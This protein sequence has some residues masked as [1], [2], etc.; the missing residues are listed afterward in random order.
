MRAGLLA[1]GLVALA[2]GCANVSPYS[3]D[4]NPVS[5]AGAGDGGLCQV[6]VD[7][8]PEV[9]IAGATATVIARSAIA[10]SVGLVSYRWTISH[11]GAPIEP[12]A[13]TDGRRDVEFP[14]PSPG[15]YSVWLEVGD[16]CQGFYGSLNVLPPGANTRAVRLRFVPPPSAQ[17]PPQEQIVTVTGGS[18]QTVNVI[19]LDAGQLFPVTVRAGDQP[20][21]AYL[22]FISRTTPDAAV[23]AFSDDSGAST[24]R[25]IAGQYDVLVV[26]TSAA[27]APRLITGFDPFTRA[28]TVDGGAAL[29]GVV[30][31]GAGVPVAGARVSVTSGATPS[32]V[33]TTAAD[34][35][36][37]LRWRDDP[38][39]TETLTIA[40]LAGGP[41]PRVDAALDLAGRSAVD[42]RFAPIATRDLAGLV[43]RA[44]GGPAVATEVVVHATVATAATLLDGAT[45]IGTAAGSYRRQVRTD[46]AGALPALQVARVPGA[47]VAA[48]AG[49]AAMRADLG[50]A[51]RFDLAT[52]TAT[53]RVLGRDGAPIGGGVTVRAVL[54]GE[55]AFA[56]A[57]VTTA[58]TTADGRFAI[59]IAAGVSY[60]LTVAAPT[61]GHAELA[62]AVTSAGSTAALG[63]LRL[64]A[65]LTVSG[66]VRATGQS[67]GLGA[68]GI[69]ALCHLDCA[70]LDRSRP[71]GSAVTDAFGGFRV[72]IP[73]PGVAGP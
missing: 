3:D 54:V 24:V 44:G 40:P 23:E 11:A 48:H 53:G 68:V 35:S 60:Q 49:G 26:P 65:A 71:L 50:T 38:A 61:A 4:D 32:T 45:P 51:T 12:T 46:D 59:E 1:V 28:L 62:V 13:L 47:I 30:R 43:V 21:S 39:A 19:S 37:R 72:R 67:A 36:Y 25:L 9:P 22:R 14:V 73:D 10:G 2:A 33:A 66:E 20:V 27:L 56:S 57:P 55:F 52:A 42:V 8:T 18:D 17:V 34:G 7:F 64:P 15:I 6:R 16:G 5:D 69:A 70:G 63:D 58:T 41:L 31:D 29:T